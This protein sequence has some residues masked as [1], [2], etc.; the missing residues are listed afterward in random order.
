MREKYAIIAIM[1]ISDKTNENK[2]LRMDLIIMKRNM[3]EKMKKRFHYLN[4]GRFFVQP[5]KH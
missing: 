2:M 5:F 1:K 4:R 3:S